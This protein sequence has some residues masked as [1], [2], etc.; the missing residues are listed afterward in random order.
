MET[1]ASLKTVPT[2]HLRFVSG[3]LQQWFCQSGWEWVNPWNREHASKVGE[4][5]SVQ[6]FQADGEVKS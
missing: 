4:W 1:M 3:V 5:R 6:S 2:A